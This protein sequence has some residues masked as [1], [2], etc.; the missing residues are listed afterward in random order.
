MGIG[1]IL[2]N[3]E[4]NDLELHFIA[5]RRPFAQLRPKMGHYVLLIRYTQ[6]D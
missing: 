2:S 4:P 5:A 6:R 3:K 1:R